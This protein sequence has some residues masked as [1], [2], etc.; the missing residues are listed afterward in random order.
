MSSR[1]AALLINGMG[2]SLVREQHQEEVQVR[3]N[4]LLV[5]RCENKFAYERTRRLRQTVHEQRETLRSSTITA[6]HS[7]FY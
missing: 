7:L 6:T 2:G 4:A 1:L 5:S 3:N